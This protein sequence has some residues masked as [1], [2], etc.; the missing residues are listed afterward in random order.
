MEGAE[1]AEA[2]TRA[3]AEG[4]PPQYMGRGIQFEPRLQVLQNQL[5]LLGIE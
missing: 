1:A 5:S 3:A 4:V 2:A